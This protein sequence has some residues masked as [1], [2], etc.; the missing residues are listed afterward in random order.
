[1]ITWTYGQLIAILTR[2]VDAKTAPMPDVPYA[3]HWAY[4]N[5]V[6]AAAYGWIQ[7]AASVQPYRIVTRGEVV[8]LVNSIFERCADNA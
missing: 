4:K 5:I 3:A 6:T 8:E 1:M 7:D 2:F